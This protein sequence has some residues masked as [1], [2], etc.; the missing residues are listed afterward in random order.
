MKCSSPVLVSLHSHTADHMLCVCGGN[1]ACNRHRM[2][3]TCLSRVH[4]L[5]C[6]VWW[7]KK[8]RTDTVV[9]AVGN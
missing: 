5:T 8:C 1:R 4:A 9:V 3:H 2:M 6:A 7:F